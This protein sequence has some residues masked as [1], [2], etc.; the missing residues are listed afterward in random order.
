MEILADCLLTKLF[1]LL[2][3]TKEFLVKGMDT[4]DKKPMYK[5][6]PLLYIQV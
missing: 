2:G 5:H 1:E 3:R 6:R 4:K